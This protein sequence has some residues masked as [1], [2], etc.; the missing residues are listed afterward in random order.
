MLERHCEV[1]AAAA[2]SKETGRGDSASHRYN[3]GQARKLIQ[4]NY[5]I[6]NQLLRLLLNY[7]SYASIL[8]KHSIHIILPSRNILKHSY[9]LVLL[10]TLVA[11]VDS[12][13][14]LW[15]SRKSSQ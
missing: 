2:G 10:T 14:S 3:K 1:V 12:I 8:L 6:V 13:V 11:T 15:T 4:Q 5:N 7:L 9:N